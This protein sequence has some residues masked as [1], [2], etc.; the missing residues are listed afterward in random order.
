MRTA[1]ICPT[2][3]TYTNAVCVIYDGPANLTN[4]PASPLQ[5]IDQILVA[6]NTTIGTINDDITDLYDTVVFSV[7]GVLPTSGNV[8]LPAKYANSVLP[9]Y[10][11]YAAALAALGS[12]PSGY[13]YLYHD[14][15]T[16]SIGAVRVP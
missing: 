14:Q 8:T 6:L 13:T 15:T 1:A 7:N 4:I 2:C 5:N 9:T 3:A 16:L 12:N 10:L 11:N